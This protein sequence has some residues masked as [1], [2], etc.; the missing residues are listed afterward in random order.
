MR[1]L[2]QKSKN[3]QELFNNTI[4]H[5]NSNNRAMNKSGSCRYRNGEGRGCAIGREISDKLASRLDKG[6]HEGAIGLTH[7]VLHKLVFDSLPTR[8]KNM[9]GEFLYSLQLLHDESTN[10]C[11][12]GLSPRGVV[13]SKRIA[14]SYNLRTSVFE[15]PF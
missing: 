12:S 14:K 9:G 7:I 5:F 11:P 2:M 3:R 4:T 10:W 13:A 15:A 6:V 1:K 8:L